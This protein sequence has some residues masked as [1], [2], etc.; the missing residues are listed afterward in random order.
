MADYQDAIFSKTL[1]LQRK[2]V[3][4]DVKENRQG[5]YLKVCMNTMLCHQIGGHRTMVS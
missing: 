1:W 3:F 5:L 2:R 4:I